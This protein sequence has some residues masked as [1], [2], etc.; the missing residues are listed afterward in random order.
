VT[1]FEAEIIT[2]QGAIFGKLKLGYY[3]MVFTNYPFEDRL[4]NNEFYKFGST[5]I[6]NLYHLLFSGKNEN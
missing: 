3:G 5:V 2:I 1:E 6:E 4:E